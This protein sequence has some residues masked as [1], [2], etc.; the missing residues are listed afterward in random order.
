MTEDDGRTYV[1]SA[2]TNQ[3]KDASDSAQEEEFF[4]CFEGALTIFFITWSSLVIL[5]HLQGDFREI[6]KMSK[7]PTISKILGLIKHISSNLTMSDHWGWSRT[8]MILAAHLSPASAE[9]YR[10][11]ENYLRGS[12]AEN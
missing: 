11:T 1:L 8:L 6:G 4:T 7:F 5:F 9:D 2:M 3:P 10:G 12:K